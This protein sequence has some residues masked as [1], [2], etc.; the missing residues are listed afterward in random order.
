MIDFTNLEAAQ[1]YREQ[2]ES[3]KKVMEGRKIG[4]FDD[5]CLYEK[6]RILSLDHFFFS[7]WYIFVQI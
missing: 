6:S 2:L 4:E 3:M 7:A 1:W 5:H